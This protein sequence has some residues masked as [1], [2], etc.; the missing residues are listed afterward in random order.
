MQLVNACISNKQE[1]V[2]IFYST[3]VSIFLF[4]VLTAV[5][6]CVDPCLD[7]GSSIGRLR[8]QSQKTGRRSSGGSWDKNLLITQV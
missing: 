3:T 8:V 5:G 4:Y 6:T 1:N 2:V 7:L